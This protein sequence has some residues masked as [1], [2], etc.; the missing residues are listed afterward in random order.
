MEVFEG[1]VKTQTKIEQLE[2]DFEWLEA[3]YNMMTF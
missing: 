1:L 2:L 3:A